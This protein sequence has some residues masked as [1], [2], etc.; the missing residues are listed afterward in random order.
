MI[1]K[2][3]IF[4]LTGLLL[5]TLCSCSKESQEYIENEISKQTEIELKHARLSYW[6]MQPFLEKIAEFLSDASGA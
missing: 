4:S 3:V 2:L 1:R 5:I 6:R